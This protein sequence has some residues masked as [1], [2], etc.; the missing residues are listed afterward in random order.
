MTHINLL[1]KL[2]PWKNNLHELHDARNSNLIAFFDPRSQESP[3]AHTAH[4][5]RKTLTM[6]SRTPIPKEKKYTMDG[7]R[8]ARLSHS[9]LLF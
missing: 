5:L 3:C 6:G 2:R 4:I 1:A 7:G 8:M 9:A